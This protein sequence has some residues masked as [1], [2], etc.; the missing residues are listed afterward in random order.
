[1]VR[2]E[3]LGSKSLV[4]RTALKSLSGA[5]LNV[6]TSLALLVP[7]N[8][9]ERT[10]WLEGE[11]PCGDAWAEIGGGRKGVVAEGDCPNSMGF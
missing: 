6:P 4:P 10:W 3:G 8:T 5:D 9:L 2:F 1:V 7:S 11:I